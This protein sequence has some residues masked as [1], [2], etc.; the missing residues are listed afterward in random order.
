MSS[1]DWK[2]NIEDSTD[3]NCHNHRNIFCTK[4][5][6][7]K[8]TKGIPGCYGYHETCR[9]N[10]RRGIGERLCSPQEMD[11]RVMQQKFYGPLRATKLLFNNRKVWRLNVN[12]FV[13]QKVSN[14]CPLEPWPSILIG[15]TFFISQW[16][17]SCWGR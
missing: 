5:G 3:H 14:M 17:K 4:S 9:W 15:L 6:K 13:F 2:K 1:F 8:T 12:M 10:L 11:Q 16:I 7:R